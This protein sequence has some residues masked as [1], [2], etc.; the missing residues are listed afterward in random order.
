MRSRELVVDAEGV[1]HDW[2]QELVSQLLTVQ[3]A[4]GS[5]V[6]ENGRWMEQIPDLVTAYPLLA[7]QYAAEGW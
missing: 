2:R 1:A 3:R 4:D 7:I 6:N 5:W